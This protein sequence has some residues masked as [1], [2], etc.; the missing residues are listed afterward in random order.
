MPF[1]PCA[2]L[3][4]WV[5]NTVCLTEYLIGHDRSG[6]AH[7]RYRAQV[8]TAGSKLDSG[9]PKEDNGRGL[10]D[11]VSGAHARYRALLRE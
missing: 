3:L 6:G 10:E 2:G 4:E 7:A 9:C 1:S 5:N 11:G 8:S